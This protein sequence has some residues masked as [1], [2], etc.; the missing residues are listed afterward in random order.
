MEEHPLLIIHDET[1]GKQ[2][3][4]PIAED[5][6]YIGREEAC[7]LCLPDRQISREHAKIF[8][9]DDGY[10]VRDE[11]SK[12]GTFLNGNLIALPR[13]LNDGDEIRIAARYRIVFVASEATAP[14]YRSGPTPH[15]IFLDRTTRRVWVE[16]VEVDPPLSIAQYRLLEFLY[17]RVDAICSRN[18]IVD[19]VWADKSV[20]G[21]SDQ[22]ID[23]LVGRLRSRLAE[24][25]ATHEYIET[26]RGYGFRLNQP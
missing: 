5:A 10:F 14:L 12:N 19:A 3:E 7:D 11:G 8:R 15:G 1:T 13:P 20:E 23:A 6:L 2:W 17:D 16:G 21:V 9:Q 26:A 24:T 22:A 4:R 25:G 18:E